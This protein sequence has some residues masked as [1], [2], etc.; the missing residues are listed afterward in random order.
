MSRI[1]STWGV[2]AGGQVYPPSRQAD[3]PPGQ[4][5]VIQ[6]GIQ[7]SSISKPVRNIWQKLMIESTSGPKQR[8]DRESNQSHYEGTDRKLSNL[9]I[10]MFF[11]FLDSPDSTRD[12]PAVTVMGMRQGLPDLP[13]YFRCFP[14]KS[15]YLPC[16]WNIWCVIRFLSFI[17]THEQSCGKV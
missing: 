12:I 16:S 11:I 6:N 1:L 8:L 17:T 7:I 10:F 9:S 2:G 5:P 3:T 14:C 4:T 15:W 13:G